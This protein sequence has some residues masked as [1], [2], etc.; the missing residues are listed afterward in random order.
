VPA[1]FAAGDQLVVAA[2]D[3][4]WICLQTL[5]VMNIAAQVVVA[6]GEHNSSAVDICSFVLLA[7][8]IWC[9]DGCIVGYNQL[10]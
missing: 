8:N 3:H 5:S 9:Y 6:A 4:N 7:V 10:Y 1:F 2:A